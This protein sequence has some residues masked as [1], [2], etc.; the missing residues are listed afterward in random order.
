MEGHILSPGGDALIITV[1]EGEDYDV[2]V[3]VFLFKQEL[4]IGM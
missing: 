4:L 3:L 1:N 2:H